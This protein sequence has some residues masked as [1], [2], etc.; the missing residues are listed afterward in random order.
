MADVAI[1]KAGSP[2]VGPAKAGASV[3]E[4]LRALDDSAVVSQFLGGVG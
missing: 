4:Q 3:R 2:V 1:K